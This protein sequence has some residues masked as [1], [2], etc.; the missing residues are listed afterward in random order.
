MCTVYGVRAPRE[1]AEG[2]KKSGLSTTSLP[3]ITISS[4]S[5]TAE[6][7]TATSA[8]TANTTT[9]SLVT[10]K[11]SATVHSLP[12]ANKENTA[13]PSS[14]TGTTTSLKTKLLTTTGSG[15]ETASIIQYLNYYLGIIVCLMVCIMTRLSACACIKILRF[16]TITLEQ[17]RDIADS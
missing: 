10:I 15:A 11:P 16:H 8:S 14:T 9:S 17:T 4:S 13:T 7:N 12:S 3:T 2:R 1:N 6:D 5:S